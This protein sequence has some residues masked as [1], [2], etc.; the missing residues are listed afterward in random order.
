MEQKIDFNKYKIKLPQG[1]K[2]VDSRHYKR[3]LKRIRKDLP[4]LNG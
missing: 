2:P 1:P 4:H 3:M